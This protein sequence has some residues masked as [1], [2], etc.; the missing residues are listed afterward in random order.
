MP[1]LDGPH[2]FKYFLEEHGKVYP[3]RDVMKTR[4]RMHVSWLMIK[5]RYT[6][7]VGSVEGVIMEPTTWKPVPSSAFSNDTVTYL[8]I[9]KQALP[10]PPVVGEVL[11]VMECWGKSYDLVW[12]NRVIGYLGYLLSNGFQLSNEMQYTHFEPQTLSAFP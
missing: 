3:Y 11:E 1:L 7:Y 10:A 8:I 6:G 4:N 2:V 9:T 5:G 12:Y